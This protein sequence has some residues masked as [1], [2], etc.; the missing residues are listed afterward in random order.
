MAEASANVAVVALSEDALEETVAR[1]D[2]TGCDGVAYP[3]DVTD[4]TSVE[5]ELG[6]VDLLVN[7]ACINPFFGSP[8][9]VR[10]GFAS[11]T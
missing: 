7:N 11:K 6:P 1:I 9:S 3:V 10:R 8:V 2:D 5:A 4:L